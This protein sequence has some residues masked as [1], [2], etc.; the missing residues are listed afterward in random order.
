MLGYS[1]V[2]IID[3]SVLGS[4]RHD[5]NQEASMRQFPILLIILIVSVLGFAGCE[6]IGDIFKAGVWVGAILVIGIIG[7]IAWMFFKAGS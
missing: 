2:R 5:R 3:A 1:L 7:L 6:L 4:A